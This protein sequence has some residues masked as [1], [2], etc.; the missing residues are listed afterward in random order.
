MKIYQLEATSDKIQLVALMKEYFLWLFDMMRSEYGYNISEELVDAVIERNQ[1]SIEDCLPPTGL[2]LLAENDNA[3]AGMAGL[4]KLS[5]GI[6]EIKRLYVRPEFRGQ[7]LA[8]TMFQQLIDEA[9]SKNYSL[10]RLE[11]DFFMKNAHRLYRSFGFKEIEQYEG[12]I[13]PKEFV[14]H[15]I[16]MELSLA[17]AD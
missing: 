17:N 1:A 3:L 4:R 12:S 2:L 8:R 5:E 11:S 15:S 10:I 7:G 13:A 6:A 9:K 14:S 16:F